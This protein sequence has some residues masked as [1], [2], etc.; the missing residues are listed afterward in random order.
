VINSN[1]KEI[2]A[3]KIGI[4]ILVL[5]KKNL[6][7]ISEKNENN[8][9]IIKR[10]NNETIEF[11]EMAVI[12]KKVKENNLILGSIFCKK[13]FLIENFSTNIIS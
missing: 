7:G 13:A 9:K 8:I 5:K 4:K 10:G 11:E 3:A 12:I 2:I 1:G 6:K